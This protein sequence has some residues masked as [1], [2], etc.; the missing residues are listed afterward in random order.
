MRTLLLLLAMMAVSAC[1]DSSTGSLVATKAPTPEQIR[2]FLER[3]FTDQDGQPLRLTDLAG[4]AVLLS[5]VYTSC[6]IQT[7]CPLTTKKMA[8]IQAGLPE[9]LKGRVALVSITLDPERDPPAA[10]KGYGE[11]YGADFASWSFLTAGED[12][13]RA[14]ASCCN[15]TFSLEDNGMIGHN[16][17]LVILSPDGQIAHE[18]PGIDWKVPSVIATLRKLFS[19]SPR[20]S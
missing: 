11:F 4:Q 20:Q 3:P 16:M 14:S 19:A 1:A 18:Y 12:A 2:D 9:D 15:V 5:Y 6:P 13:I 7:M 8:Q 10:L 17:N